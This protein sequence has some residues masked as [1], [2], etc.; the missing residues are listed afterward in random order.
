MLPKSRIASR[1]WNVTRVVARMRIRWCSV[2]NSKI[3][4]QVTWKCLV[5]T[6]SLVG[7]VDAGLEDVG[8]RIALEAA[9]G[10]DAARAVLEVDLGDRDLGVVAEHLL[11]QRDVLR[12]VDVVELLVQARSSSSW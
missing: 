3:C 11:E 7:L 6:Q 5:A 8:E 12:L 10:E 4:R 9:R 1:G 2:P